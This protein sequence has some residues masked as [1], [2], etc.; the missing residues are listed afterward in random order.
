MIATKQHNDGYPTI[1][2]VHKFY[3][4]MHEYRDKGHG[5][6][7]R[8]VQCFLYFKVKYTYRKYTSLSRFDNFFQ[9]MIGMHRGYIS[10]NFP[11]HV[12]WVH[13]QASSRDP[14][15]HQLGIDLIAK[16][17]L[18]E[19]RFPPSHIP[20]IHQVLIMVQAL[21]MDPGKPILFLFMVHPHKTP[22][23]LCV[24]YPPRFPSVF[25]FPRFRDM[26]V[27]KNYRLYFILYTYHAIYTDCTDEKHFSLFCLCGLVFE[28]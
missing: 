24:A 12:A 13:Y 15:Y 26:Q 25:S 3:R 18:S 28:C 8:I 20:T 10:L 22:S 11:I 1:V 9:E 23:C 21:Q 5:A 7:N 17:Y 16:R 6:W 2:S 4:G 27:Q 19:S 14:N